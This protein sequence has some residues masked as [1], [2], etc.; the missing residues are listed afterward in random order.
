VK[1]KQNKPSRFSTPELHTHPI[2]NDWKN[3]ED[4]YGYRILFEQ[5]G[6]ALFVAQDGIIIIHNPKSTELFGYLSEEFHA[7]PFVEFIHEDDRQMVMDYY[8]QRLKGEN[9][10][11][12]YSFRI[13]HQTGRIL[14]VRINAVMIQWN[15][16]P[17]V[18]FFMRDITEC[19]QAEQALKQSKDRLSRVLLCANDGWWEWDLKNDATY[20]SKR[21]WEMLGYAKNELPSESD[22]WRRLM[23]PDDRFR[24]RRFLNRTLASN[25]NRY[26]IELRLRHKDG[27]FIPVLSKAYIFRDAERNIIRISGI[28]IDLSERKQTEAR[29][30]LQILLF[31]QVQ[32]RIAITDLEGII[33]YVN[34]AQAQALGYSREELIGVPITRFDK[35][36]DQGITRREMITKTLAHGRWRSEIFRRTANDQVVILD[37][38]TQ[39][40]LDENGNKAALAFISTDITDQKK[41]EQMKDELQIQLNQAQKMESVGRLA[42]GVAH[43]FNNMLGVILGYVDLALMKAGDRHDGNRELEEIQTAAKRS[44]DLIKQLLTFASK[45]IIDPKPLNLNAAIEKMLNILRRLIGENIDLIWKPAKFPC[46]VKIDPTQID[47]VLANLCVNARDAIAGVGTISIETGRQSFD[48]DYCRENSDCT[49]GEFVL[50]SVR[51]NGCGIDQ[52]HLDHLFE[53]FFTTKEVGKGTG[54]GLAT[55]YGVV[56][57][58]NGFINVYS[59]PGWGT[60]FNIYL[61]LLKADEDV[62]AEKTGKKPSFGGTETILVVEDEP[63]ILRMIRMMLKQKGYSVISAATPTQALEKME[64]HADVIDLLLT[65]VIMPEMNGLD[66]SRQIIVECPPA[67]KLPIPC[68]RFQQ[69]A[70][71]VVCFA[72]YRLSSARF[73]N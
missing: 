25:L 64:T 41:S 47:Q 36:L 69:I 11:A 17:A 70:F 19:R 54:L 31:N 59:E 35:G 14:W 2:E 50:L 29:L 55:V 68:F 20:Y 8:L 66:L 27:H 48:E 51:D 32:D 26:E 16:R 24:A 28:N 37:C 56:K 44:V 1:K 4:G 34:D 22:L 52:D 42:G 62:T 71:R 60:T 10:P 49:P 12:R 3:S 40:V 63:A 67:L 39:I 46:P 18:L 58:N 72:L 45:Q 15:T 21:W 65:D 43:D 30:H 6:E 7:K 33:T 53:P 23:H 13:I 57:Q 5:T 9:P 73:N 38:R 61:P